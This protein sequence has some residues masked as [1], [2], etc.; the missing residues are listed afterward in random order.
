MKT[1][2]V[3][4]FKAHAL[5][6]ISEV[7]HTREPV[8]L[9]KRGMPVVELVPYTEPVHRAGKLAETLV[10]EGDILTPVAENDWEASR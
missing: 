1:M 5:N 2:S 3:T 8:V 9:T 6:V 4:D 7:S 10:Y